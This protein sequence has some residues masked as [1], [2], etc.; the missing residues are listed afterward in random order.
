MHLAV[1]TGK[2][3]STVKH[4]AYEN[5]KLLLVQKLD[6]DRKASGPP[7]I[8]IDYVGAGEGDVVIL[9]AAPGLASS[10]FGIPDAPMRELV[11][12]V[13]DAVRFTKDHKDF[14]NSVE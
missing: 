13:I 14:G 10:V 2:V 8:A 9:G 12:G 7:T 11:M 5:R 1:V 6:L 4:E 3:I